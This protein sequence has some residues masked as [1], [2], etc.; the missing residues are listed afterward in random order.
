MESRV[1]QFDRCDSVTTECTRIP[2]VND[3][4]LEG[5]EFFNVSVRTDVE[6]IEINPSRATVRIYGDNDSKLYM[7]SYKEPSN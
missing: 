3:L 1:I 7:I 6:D 4:V 5:D 2:I